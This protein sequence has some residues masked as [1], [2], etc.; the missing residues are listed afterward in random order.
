M[1]CERCMV[2]MRKGV[3]S[4]RVSWMEPIMFV[5]VEFDDGAWE[6]RWYCLNERDMLE[7]R[8]ES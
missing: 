5:V 1:R 6:I 2:P 7:L 3:K 4:L 8:D